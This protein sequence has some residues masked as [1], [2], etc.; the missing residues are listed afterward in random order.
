[1][2]WCSGV[3]TLTEDHVTVEHFNIEGEA[4]E[5]LIWAKRRIE[6]AIEDERSAESRTFIG[7]EPQGP[8]LLP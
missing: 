6:R 7:A 5:A 2:I 3:V 8:R 4:I 1:M